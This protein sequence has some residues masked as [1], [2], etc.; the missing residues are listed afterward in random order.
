MAS[1]LAALKRRISLAVYSDAERRFRG[2]FANHA[3]ALAAVGPGRL[4]GYDNDE[5]AQV[6]FELMCRVE[7]WDYPVLFWLDRVLQDASSLVDA[8]G[9]MGTKYRAFR[10]LLPLT[11]D[12]EWIV[13]DVP[14]VVRAGRER[15]RIEGLTALRFHD[16]VA[17]LPETG[18]LLGSGL[19]QYLDMPFSRFI[20]AMPAPPTHL[21]LNKVATREGESVVMLERFPGSEVPYT[22]LNRAEFEAELAALGYAIVDQWEIWPH[23]HELA[24]IGRTTSRGYYAQ[25]VRT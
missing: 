12:F 3:D 5:T 2:R 4:A 13:Y 6:A 17:D 9:H 1:S 25:R 23:S 10:N 11:P 15:A 21:V 8:A 14:A 20:K 22:V 7:Q 24:S 16:R 18:V 19:L